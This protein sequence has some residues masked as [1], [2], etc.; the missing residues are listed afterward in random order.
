DDVI[1][2][3]FT[4]T[5]K[6]CR[7]LSYAPDGVRLRFT[8]RRATPSRDESLK[9]HTGAAAFCGLID[10]WAESRRP[11]SDKTGKPLT[12]SKVDDPETLP[13]CASQDRARIVI[14]R[15][16]PWLSSSHC[17]IGVAFFR[18]QFPCLEQINPIQRGS[19]WLFSQL[20]L[21]VLSWAQSR[22]Y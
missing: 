1:K 4:H 11:A 15:D 17:G 13:R 7:A 3:V 5:A 8:E 22:S 18:N 12:A 16:R 20:F 2:R 14:D 9:Q 21:S 6:I 10:L 19:L